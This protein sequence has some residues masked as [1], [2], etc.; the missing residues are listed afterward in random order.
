MNSS[1]R[2]AKL[3][4]AYT[5]I[6]DTE[7][8]SAQIGLHP[9]ILTHAAGLSVSV[10]QGRKPPVCTDERGTDVAAMFFDVNL[11]GPCANADLNI[12]EI[13]F[14]VIHKTH[15]NRRCCLFDGYAS[16]SYSL[17]GS[18]MLYLQVEGNDR[19]MIVNDWPFS[20]RDTNVK[21]QVLCTQAC[22][23]ITIEVW[24]RNQSSPKTFR[25]GYHAKLI[26]QN[27][28][29]SVTFTQTRL[30]LRFVYPRPRVVSW[31]QV[32]FHHRCYITPKA[33]MP[34]VVT[35]NE[36]KAACEREQ[37]TLVSIN[38]DLEWALLTRRPQRKGEELIELYEIILLYI[39]LVSDVSSS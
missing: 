1:C 17:Q 10:E 29:T 39:G 16:T 28:F 26:E 24:L 14:L 31:N 25:I 37:A 12:Q 35:W 22:L 2:F 27:D 36:A 19:S 34:L 18:L 20:D 6:W 32:C 4:S 21:F 9:S 7:A 5:G 11:L 13:R 38:S 8:Y 30:P 15:S 23:A 3:T 33:H